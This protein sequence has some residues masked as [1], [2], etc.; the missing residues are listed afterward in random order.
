MKPCLS[1]DEQVDL[2]ISRGFIVEDRNR[3]LSCLKSRNYY[4]FSGYA[5]Y[6][7]QAPH[8]DNNLF[9]PDVSFENIQRIYDADTSIR[10]KLG[11]QLARAECLLCT[12]TAYAIACNYLPYR[13]YLE[14]SFHREGENHGSTAES[15]LLNEAPRF[16]HMIQMHAI[17]EYPK[18]SVLSHSISQFLDDLLGH[19]GGTCGDCSQK[20]GD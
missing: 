15:S 19:A 16:K 7:Q 14:P 11:C 5:R 2:L 3:C 20:Y 13:D 4:R 10:T 1:W 12:H 17:T 18:L 8:A 9:L 6:F